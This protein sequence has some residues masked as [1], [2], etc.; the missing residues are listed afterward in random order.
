MSSHEINLEDLQAEI[1][2]AENYLKNRPVV[3]SGSSIRQSYVAPRANSAA[4]SSELKPISVSL[5]G[6]LGTGWSSKFDE[7][8]PSSTEIIANRGTSSR[9]TRETPN[10][11]S[12]SYSKAVAGDRVSR[13]WDASDNLNVNHADTHTAGSQSQAQ[14]H[15]PSFEP[16]FNPVQSPGQNSPAQAGRYAT[17]ASREQLISRLLAEHGSKSTSAVNNIA[18]REDVLIEK[19]QPFVMSG[20]LADM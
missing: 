1:S 4:V 7:F 10:N 20:Q 14:M 16:S 11:S 12:Y 13:A 3:G 8:E 17:E 18:D 19:P 15:G 6:P 5:D 9:D 2:A